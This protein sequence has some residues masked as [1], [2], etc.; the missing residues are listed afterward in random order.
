M[1]PVALGISLVALTTLAF[2]N[3]NF[4]RIWTPK[5]NV[6]TVS[7]SLTK[8]TKEEK[9]KYFYLNNGSNEPK[10]SALAY[11]VGDLNTGEVI[12]AKNQDKK[13]PIASLSKLMTAL[14]ASLIDTPDDTALVSRHALATA[15]TNGELRL[16]E[17]VKTGDLIYPLLLESSNDAAEVLAEHFDRESFVA[18]MNQEASNLKMSST[19]YEDPSGLSPNN[20][21]TVS[22]LFKLTG[23][24]NQQKPDL[25]QITTKRS[26]STK[27]HN[28]SNIS[29]FLGDEGYIGGKSGY[30][31]PA[32]QTVV[33]LFNL[34]LGESGV[35]PISITLLQSTDR[36]KDVENILKYLKKNIYYGGSADTST[37]WVKEK[38]GTPNIKDPDFITFVFAGDIML[39]RGVKNSVRKNFNNDYSAL[40]TKLEILKKSDIVFANLEGTASDKG[41]DLRNLYSF[42]MDP[43]VVP[44]LRGAGV[45]VLSVANN[46]IGDWGRNSYID[47]LARLKENEILYTGGGNDKNEAETPVII[48]KYGMK[49]GFL[50]FSDVGPTAMQA[51]V[52][53]A[54]QLLASD[55]RFEEIIQNAAKQVDYL[56]ISFHFGTEYKNI[57]NE[58]QEYLAHKA[59]DNGAKLVIGHHPHVAQDTEVYKNSFI[60]YSLGNFIFDQAF[61]K[62]TMQGMLL[63]VK[64]RRNGEM[65]VKKNIVQLNS[66]FQPDKIVEGK[67][68]KLKF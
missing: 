23:Y 53:K 40:F 15:G 25:F 20:Q 67:E 38:I 3:V 63:E 65:S 68:E 43:E 41:M 18:K 58:R 30:T 5:E 21:S 56:I 4:S 2:Q 34:P 45:S 7:Q 28:W 6:A 66:S 44:A 59:V 22:D 14:V 17:K 62:N 64:L 1:F 33:S 52:D 37:D 54:G 29:Q 60:A 49:I 11:L 39:D 27:T 16:G 51:G 9:P 32:K 47:S 12:L 55:P 8:E 46:H 36:H 10:V 24:V 13:F 31:D 57:H 50:G 19:S 42:R 61:S 48:E 35:R 26:Y